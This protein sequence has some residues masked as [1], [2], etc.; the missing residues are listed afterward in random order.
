[1]RFRS[2][3]EPPSCA[4]VVFILKDNTRP[5]VVRGP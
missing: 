5:L 1:M 3:E 4:F 2:N